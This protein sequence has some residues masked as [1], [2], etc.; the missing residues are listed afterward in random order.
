MRLPLPAPIEARDGTVEKDGLCKNLLIEKDDDALMIALRPGL[1]VSQTYTGNGNG[2]AEF[3]DELVSV[4]GATLRSG[5][6]SIGSVE[7]QFF[8]FA[9]STL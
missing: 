5:L 7:D 8:D 2:I 1:S 3:N 4:F 6:A 9:Q